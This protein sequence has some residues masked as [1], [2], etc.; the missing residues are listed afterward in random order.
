V[1]HAHFLDVQTP[2]MEEIA[3]LK[4]GIDTRSVKGAQRVK[5]DEL[6]EL[7]F[8]SGGRYAEKYHLDLICL[9]QPLDASKTSAR[10]FSGLAEMLNP[11][12]KTR[13]P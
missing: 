5:P 12:T 3:A 11:Y 7:P 1:Y 10:T 4:R 13:R 2:D 9:S 8:D 6:A